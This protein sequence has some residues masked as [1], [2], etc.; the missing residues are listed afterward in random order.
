MQPVKLFL[1]TDSGDVYLIQLY[2]I[3]LVSDMCQVHGFLRFS[4]PVK[5]TYCFA[6]TEI[7]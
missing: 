7:C 3:Q 4:E 1:K 5:L 6:I 2:E